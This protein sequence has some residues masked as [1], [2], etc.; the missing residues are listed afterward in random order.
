VKAHHTWRVLV[1]GSL[2]VFG[3][4]LPAPAARSAASGEDAWN[5]AVQ[6]ARADR[7]AADPQGIYFGLFVKRLARVQG[8]A[9]RACRARHPATASASFQAVARLSKDGTIAELLIKPT[10]EFHDCVRARIKA[11]AFPEPP[12][13]PY[14]VF[15]GNLE[16]PA[17][18]R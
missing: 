9:L 11:S 3:A 15:W 5:K 16:A 6:A 13:A 14:R 17:P 8:P 4:A 10:S 1:A 12:R 18:S 7:E 2:S